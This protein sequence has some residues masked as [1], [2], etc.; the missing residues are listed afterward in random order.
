M[1]TQENARCPARGIARNPKMSTNPHRSVSDARG[2]SVD[3]HG[4]PL[5]VV[6]TN[7]AT[8]ARF[9]THYMR[10]VDYLSHYRVNLDGMRVFL[11]FCPFGPALHVAQVVVQ[12]GV[13]TFSCRCGATHH[14][15]TQY[16]DQ[17]KGQP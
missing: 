16:V 10:T 3:R 11:M 6:W 8:P 5:R 13:A 15:F 9:A 4:T 2:G 14:R 7:P 17:L 1:T 12:G